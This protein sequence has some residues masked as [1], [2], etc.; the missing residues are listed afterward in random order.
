MLLFFL[1]DCDDILGLNPHTVYSGSGGDWQTQSFQEILNQ[2][3]HKE[4]PCLLIVARHKLIYL[5]IKIEKIN[6]SK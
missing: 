6:E 2:C 4:Y 3:L 5:S 1:G